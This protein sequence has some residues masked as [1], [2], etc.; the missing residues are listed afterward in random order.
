MSGNPSPTTVLL[1]D[2]HAIVAEGLAAL[3]RESFTLMGCVQDGRELLA[4]S[5]RLRP[6]VIVTDVS[7]PKLNGLDAIRQI[8]SSRPDAKI[9]VLTMHADPDLAVQA[10]RAGASGYVLKTSPAEELLTAIR[11]AAQGRVFLTPLIA[12]ELLDVLLEAREEPR[13]GAK[14]TPRQREVLQLIAE[15][16]TMKEIAAVL[17]ISPRTAESHKYEMMATL[18]ATTTAGLIQHA[19]RMKLVR[20]SS[21]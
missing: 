10:F 13:T 1:A 14:L 4:A 20:N 2:D 11:S 21:E 6:D 5:D 17:Q 19:L 16:R 15:G 8:R 9:V 18:G 12:R 7:M 3:L